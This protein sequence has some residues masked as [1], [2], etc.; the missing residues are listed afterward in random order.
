MKVIINFFSQHNYISGYVVLHVYSSSRNIWNSNQ[1]MTIFIWRYEHS[2]S[3]AQS[4]KVIKITLLRNH[5]IKHFSS[6]SYTKFVWS[7]PR[8]KEESFQEKFIITIW[9]MYTP[10][11]NKIFYPL[12]SLGHVIC[13]SG[14]PS[15]V[16]HRYILVNA[17]KCKA[18]DILILNCLPLSNTLF[19]C[20]SLYFYRRYVTNW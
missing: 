16:H 3:R 8:S 7:M 14:R 20:E 11:D 18:I 12:S 5:Y 2:L 1:R 6:S 17:K 9:H 19:D 4:P 10:Y 15:L 13:N